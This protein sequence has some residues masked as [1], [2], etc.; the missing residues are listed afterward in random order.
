MKLRTLGV[1]LM[2]LLVAGCQMG[3]AELKEDLS[4]IEIVGEADHCDQESPGLE[5]V[6]DMADFP[7]VDG[8]LPAGEGAL[9][10]GHDL[11]VV[12]LGERPTPGYGGELQEVDLSGDTL[13]LSLKATEPESDAMMAQVITNPCLAVAVPDEGW[14]KL[15]VEMDADGFPLSLEAP[16]GR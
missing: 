2:S 3:Q 4:G 6:R 5:L 14:S 12:Y 10:S 15:S 13:E 9:E 8:L 7:E 11:L 16:S 1:G